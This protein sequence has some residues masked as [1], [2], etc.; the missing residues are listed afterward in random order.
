M[1][2]PLVVSTKI[3]TLSEDGNDLCE[4]GEYD[5][6]ISKWTEALS[7]VPEPREDWEAATWLY[8]SIADAYYQQQLF[9]DARAACFDGLNCPG[10]QSNPFIHLR[11]GQCEAML[12]NHQGA[13]KHLLSA[14]MLDGTE[15]FL[16]E[17]GGQAFLDILQK[18]GLI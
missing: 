18:Q 6:A 14:Y 11:L 7:L 4:H 9:E 2:L 1:T 5:A 17:E 10:G 3:E 16:A 8:G 13:A 12:G 15:I